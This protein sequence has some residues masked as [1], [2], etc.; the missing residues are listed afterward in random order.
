MA[1]IK[2]TGFSAIGF[3]TTETFTDLVDSLGSYWS[4]GKG[5][6]LNKRTT[7]RS[8]FSLNKRKLKL[9]NIP[10]SI[11]NSSQTQDT[12]LKG[13]FKYTINKN[14]SA[15]KI[16]GQIKSYE[17]KT[18]KNPY[19]PSHKT[20]VIGLRN[21]K[22]DKIINGHNKYKTFFEQ[23]IIDRQKKLDIYFSGGDNAGIVR[24]IGITNYFLTEDK[25]AAESPIRTITC[26]KSKEKIDLTG[27]TSSEIINIRNFDTKKDSIVVKGESF[28]F[29][30][31]LMLGQ[32]IWVGDYLSSESE[33]RKLVQFQGLEDLNLDD[34]KIISV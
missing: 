3:G 23:G 1:K 30:S 6:K 20:K 17:Y 2:S 32:P 11:T 27:M 4:F 13:N 10:Y 28:V 19:L 18:D 34:I 26:G 12:N 8:E 33:Y 14:T 29:G 7:S 24:D 15:L 16:K 25:N 5:N 9:S 31:N 22:I 21:T